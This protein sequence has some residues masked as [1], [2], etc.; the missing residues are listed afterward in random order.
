MFHFIS[1]LLQFF[2]YIL[3]LPIK[4]SLAFFSIFPV[5][6]QNWNATKE[7]KQLQLQYIL[8]NPTSFK[9]TKNMLLF[10]KVS[11]DPAVETNEVLFFNHKQRESL[12]HER[13]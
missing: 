6:Q 3:K 4:M 5:F 11:L 13:R 10:G 1:C 7:N 2:F 12:E 9:H 8:I